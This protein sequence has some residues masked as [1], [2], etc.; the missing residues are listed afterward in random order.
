[1]GGFIVHLNFKQWELPQIKWKKK[2]LKTL[3]ESINNTANTKAD[4]DGPA[5]TKKIETD[6]NCS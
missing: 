1:M 2:L 4:T 6:C 5:N 3:K